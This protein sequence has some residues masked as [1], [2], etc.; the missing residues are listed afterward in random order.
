MILGSGAAWR[1]GP[2]PGLGELFG[3]ERAEG[4]KSAALV[5]IALWT[6]RP[7]VLAFGS[8]DPEGFVPEMGAELIAFLAKVVERTAGRWPPVP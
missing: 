6:G 8:S 3:A 5:R 1:M 4:L 7:G 2:S